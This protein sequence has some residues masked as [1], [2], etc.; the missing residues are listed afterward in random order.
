MSKVQVG[1][2]L[3]G[4]LAML[5][6]PGWSSTACAAPG[7]TAG[8]LNEFIVELPADLRKIAGRGTLSPI[9]NARVTIAVPANFDMAPG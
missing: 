3:L 7:L 8:A 2:V 9:T 6:T 1:R 4:L 5:M